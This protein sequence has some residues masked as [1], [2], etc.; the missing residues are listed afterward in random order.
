MCYNKDVRDIIRYTW[1]SEIQDRYDST[2]HEDMEAII[3]HVDSIVSQ[4]SEAE[5][6]EL[7]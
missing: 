2:T 4:I 6:Y 7:L 3:C 1:I 5:A